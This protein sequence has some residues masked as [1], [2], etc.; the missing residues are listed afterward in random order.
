MTLIHEGNLSFCNNK[1]TKYTK[2]ELKYRRFL[3]YT[4]NMRE[5]STNGVTKN[6]M[7]IHKLEIYCNNLIFSNDTKTR[8]EIILLQ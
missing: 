1:N 7:H 5:N 4:E 6:T 2:S 8:R 3:S